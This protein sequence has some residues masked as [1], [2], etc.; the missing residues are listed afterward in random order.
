MSVDPRQEVSQAEPEEGELVE[1]EDH[2]PIIP[3]WRLPMDH[4]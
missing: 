4:V 2:S 3:E 1:E